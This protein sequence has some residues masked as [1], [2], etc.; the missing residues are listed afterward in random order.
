MP[1]ERDGL[2]ERKKRQTR[3]LIAETALRLF[4]ERGFDGVTVAE[5]AREAEVSEKTVFNYFPTKESLVYDDEDHL[6]GVLVA[7]VRHRLPGESALAAYAAALLENLTQ[8]ARRPQR[9]HVARVA[10]IAASPALRGR[11]ERLFARH[12]DALVALLAEET[13]AEPSS[14][15]PLAVAGALVA[16]RRAILSAA[17]ANALARQSSIRSA[18]L[19]SDAE[20]ALA[21]L[22]GGLASYATRTR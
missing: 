14:V 7:A 6:S 5:I 19:R 4:A 16:F 11:E 9:E 21:L 3:R 20:R 13:H 15:E 1:D 8:L 22:S 12:C 10:R 17:R 18:A 2:R